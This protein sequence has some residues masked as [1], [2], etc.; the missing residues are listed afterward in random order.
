MFSLRYSIWVCLPSRC[1]FLTRA[2]ERE[3]RPIHF[4]ILLTLSEWPLWPGNNILPGKRS[5]AT[6]HTKSVQSSASLLTPNSSSSRGETSCHRKAASRKRRTVA[7]TW[8]K[9]RWSRTWGSSTIPMHIP[10]RPQ[11]PFLHLPTRHNEAP[12]PLPTLSLITLSSSLP[13]QLLTCWPAPSKL[14]ARHGQ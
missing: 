2:K 6:K 3:R 8:P 12:L 14:D 13:A 11:L 10:M 5:S 1:T 4:P 9:A 7:S